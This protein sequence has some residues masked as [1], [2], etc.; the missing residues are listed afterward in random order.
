MDVLQWRFARA[1]GLLLVL[2]A[3][4]A[5]TALPER[6]LANPTSQMTGA[7][8]VQELF[9]GADSSHRGLLADLAD[10]A[11][12]IKCVSGDDAPVW[13]SE[14]VLA[15]EG[16][17]AVYALEDWSLVGF[18]LSRSSED[19][20]EFLG[21]AL[22]SNG[23]QVVPSGVEGTVTGVKQGGEVSWL[24]LSCVPGSNA[25]SVVIQVAMAS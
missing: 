24:S 11:A 21:K 1:A 19:A 20:L 7:E 9:V 18:S 22:E 6:V 13:F 17:A 8:V 15:I 14:E 4:V 12:G 10:E 2:F 25:T 5:A 16:A 3:G 23:W